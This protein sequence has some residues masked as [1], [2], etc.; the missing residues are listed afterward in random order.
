MFKSKYMKMTKTGQLSTMADMM[1]MVEVGNR[2]WGN[3]VTTDIG[4][5]F[6]TKTITVKPGQKLS[7]QYHNHRDEHWI[8]VSGYGVMFHGDREFNVVPG[9]YVYIPKKIVHRVT[10]TG[11]QD[12][13]FCEI[14]TGDYLNEDDIVRIE[15]D[16]GRA[17]V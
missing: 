10:N 3:Y 8:V 9:K 4:N 1:K 11:K 7:K 14:Q 16:Y 17:N 6:K 15:D 5:N 12:L 13:I 2:P